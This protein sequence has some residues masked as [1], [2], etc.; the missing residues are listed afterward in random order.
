MPVRN[1]ILD[2]LDA[3]VRQRFLAACVLCVGVILTA[4]TTW[5]L[6][7]IYRSTTLIMVEP[8]GVPEAYVKTTVTTDIEHRLNALNQEVLSRTRLEAIVKDLD[9]FREM[10]AQAVPVEQVIEAMRRRISIEVFARDNAFR[11]S[12][13][14]PSA[15]VAQ[16]VASRLAGL[17]IDE[18]LKIREQQVSGTADFLESELEKVKADLEKQESVVQGFKQQHM[19]ELPEQREGNMRTVEG[20][21]AQLQTVSMALSAALE[22]DVLLERQ[23]RGSGDAKDAP[24]QPEQ[25]EADL[26]GAR[27]RYTEDHPDVIRLRRKLAEMQRVRPD[28]PAGRHSHLPPE[29]A[30]VL[31]AT[32]AEITRLQGE[33]ENL[34]KGIEAYQ[35]RIEAAFGREQ[36]LFVLTRDY[37]VTQKKYQTLLDKKLEAQLS[38][39]LERRQK[40]E[41]F[42]VLDPAS[43]PERPARPNRSLVLLGGLAASLGLAILL[44]IGLFQIDSSLH[45]P[46]DVA[47]TC[48]VPV[49][50][51]IPRVVTNELARAARIWRLRVASLSVVAAVLGLGT[52]TLYA[53]YLF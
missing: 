53:R 33:K 8:Q 28:R 5:T 13:E 30:R 1:P 39:S 52:I 47:A 22:R 32:A 45:A 48:N 25:I 35:A 37:D 23:T 24:A 44:P 7:N 38:Q 3:V 6:P 26:A 51:V 10:R 41:R 34:E 11:I 49:L 16:Q 21:R 20:M 15:S 40:G 29:L 50:A 17:Y 19:G 18:N 12:Y 36:Q 9:L 2:Y 43:L 27:G 42:R 4:W 46:E 31:A 14:A